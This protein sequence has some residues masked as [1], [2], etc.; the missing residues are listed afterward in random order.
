[1]VIAKFEHLSLINCKNNSQFSCFI[2]P[3]YIVC[4]KT[5]ILNL[6]KYFIFT[7]IV[8]SGAGETWETFET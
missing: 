4:F 5:L 8:L 7:N 1:M 6:I 3:K 2:K